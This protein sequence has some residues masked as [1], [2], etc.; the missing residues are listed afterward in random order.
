[1]I[2]NPAI[3][4]IRGGCLHPS[5]QEQQ[6]EEAQGIKSDKKA[7]IAFERDFQR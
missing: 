1:V 3:P 5:L 4:K 6:I 7:A 2:T